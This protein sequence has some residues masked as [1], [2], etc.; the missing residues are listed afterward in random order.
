VRVDVAALAESFSARSMEVRLLTNGVDVPDERIDE[1]AGAGL[2][3][4]SVSLDSLDPERQRRIYGRD[5]VMEDVEDSLSRFREALPRRSSRIINV[6]VSRSNLDEL[7]D[8]VDFAARRGFQCSFV[9]VAL[10]GSPGAVDAFAAHAPELALTP[11]D[12]ARVKRVY[13]RLI[14]LKRGGAAI[15]NSTRFLRD[16]A[17]HLRDGVYPWS[18][19][20]GLLYLSVSPGGDISI[21]HGFPPFARYDDSD[22]RGLLRDRGNRRRFSARRAE[23]PGCM[24]PCWAETTHV[25]RSPAAALEAAGTVLRGGSA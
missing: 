16:S 9:P 21:C 17:R 4:V 24:R 15:A 1:V 2:S 23:C 11:D 12:G 8:L 13:D 19:D 14:K 20:A 22:L 7:T 6:C 25:F 3:H 18:C 10:T 5:G